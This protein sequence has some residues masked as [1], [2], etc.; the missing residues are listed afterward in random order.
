ME[1]FLK[2]GISTGTIAEYNICPGCDGLQQTRLP[3]ALQITDLGMVISTGAIAGV[4]RLQ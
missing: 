2:S 3:R 4:L 1:V